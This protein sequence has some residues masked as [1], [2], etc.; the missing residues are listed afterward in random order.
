MLSVIIS[1][2]ANLSGAIG[3]RRAA[4]RGQREKIRLSL[5]SHASPHVIAEVTPH[6]HPTIAHPTLH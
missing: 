3:R 4:E 6:G 1:P 5:P 2:G